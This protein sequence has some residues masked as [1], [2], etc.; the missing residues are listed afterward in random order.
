MIEW[1]QMSAYIFKKKETKNGT[2]RCLTLVGP[3]HPHSMLVDDE[4]FTLTNFVSKIQKFIRVHH[5]KDI[6]FMSYF[7]I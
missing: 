7:G 3:H 6:K 1:V 2:Y 5:F 4:H